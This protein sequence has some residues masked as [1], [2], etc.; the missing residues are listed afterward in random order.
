MT[1]ELY[2]QLLTNGAADKFIYIKTHS[3]IFKARCLY[4][5][6]CV[7]EMVVLNSTQLN[8]ISLGS[9]LFQTQQGYVSKIKK[10]DNCV[11]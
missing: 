6:M 2:E 11:K 9:I 8:K 3:Q 1:C 10:Q 4:L 7:Q 5:W